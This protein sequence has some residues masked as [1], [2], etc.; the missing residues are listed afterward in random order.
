MADYWKSQGRKFCDFCKCWIADN[1][2]SINFHE[3]G[4]KHKENVS[5]RLKEIHKNS[6]KQA[7]QNK[8][9]QDDIKKMEN[10][11][12]AAYLKDVENNTRDMTA[13]RLI[14][15]K[16]NRTETK[17]TSNLNPVPIATPPE[18]Q[19]RFKGENRQ[20]SQEIDPCDPILLRNVT[21]TSATTTT[22]Q[23]RPPQQRGETKPQGKGKVGKGKGK[24][25]KILDDDRPTKPFRK[26]WYEALSPEGYT[27]YWHVESNESIWEPPEEGYMTFAEQ[28]EE[29][30]EQALQE[31]LLQQ[32]EEEEAVAN[33]DVLEEKRANAERE[34]L[35]ELRKINS[36]H[37]LE[38]ENGNGNENRNEKAETKGNE[39]ETKRPYRRDCTIPVKSHPYGPWRTVEKTETKPVDLQ[40]P[41]QKQMQL[42]VFEKAEPPP[43][44]QRTFKEKT[45]TQV[46]TGD[47]DEDAKP[48]MFKKRKIA[49]KNVRKRL[50]DD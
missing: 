29:A 32:L 37:T 36:V 40:L 23:N 35:K 48:T 5:K 33:V 24:G 1:K 4:K 34:K 50:T 39:E 46:E 12:M 15:E 18:T 43:P 30:K 7:K 19:P 47:S 25:K 13:D 44:V 31:E 26:L 42:P 45:I 10:A 11:A 20:F 41:Q 14:K 38:S 21:A 16:F 28:Q 49:N 6:A 27:Y 17:D 3:G 2:P 22:Q 9:I 8:K